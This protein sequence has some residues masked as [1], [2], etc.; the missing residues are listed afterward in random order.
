MFTVYDLLLSAGVLLCL[1][2][3]D[4]YYLGSSMNRM[5]NVPIFNVAPKGVCIWYLSL[6]AGCLVLLLS[7]LIVF[8]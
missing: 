1:E 8:V 7:F 4:F 3:T 2:M 5:K 6:D